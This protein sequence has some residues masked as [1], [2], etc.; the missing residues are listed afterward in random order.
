MKLPFVNLI[1]LMVAPRR[2]T[3]CLLKKSAPAL[4]IEAEEDERG[5][6]GPPLKYG[7]VVR[8]VDEEAGLMCGSALVRHELP[9]AAD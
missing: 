4:E 9:S 7:S 1:F 2:G 3:V 6:S 8:N 5:R